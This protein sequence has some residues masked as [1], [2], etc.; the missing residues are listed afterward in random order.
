VAPDERQLLRVV[1]EDARSALF[2]V[3]GAFSHKVS[4]TL[5]EENEVYTLVPIRDGGPATAAFTGGDIEAHTAST[6]DAA[7]VNQRRLAVRDV[8]PEEFLFLCG[9]GYPTTR[10][11]E[12]DPELVNGFGR[13]I[14]RPQ[15]FSMDDAPARQFRARRR[16]L[17]G[18]SHLRLPAIATPGARLAPPSLPHFP[19]CSTIA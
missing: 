4:G 5:R 7:I 8:M 16:R 15:V 1:P 9:D 13:A 12:Q 6:A 3:R 19:R 2:Q 11:I 10:T 17:S 18:A 14:V